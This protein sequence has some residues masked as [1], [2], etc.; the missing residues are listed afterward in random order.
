MKFTDAIVR[1]CRLV[2][3]RRAT[4]SFN[5]TDFPFHN[6]GQQFNSTEGLTKVKGWR[7]GGERK[8]RGGEKGGREKRETE[9]STHSVA[10]LIPRY[11][12]MLIMAR[13]DIFHGKIVISFERGKGAFH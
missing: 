13:E 2:A 11:K 10:Y 7:G 1:R 5:F 12:P 9:R 3:C 4:K 8:G 6:T